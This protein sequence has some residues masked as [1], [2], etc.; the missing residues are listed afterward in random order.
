MKLTVNDRKCLW[1]IRHKS[2]EE[3][4]TIAEKAG[5]PEDKLEELKAILSE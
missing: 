5:V 1:I 3:I 2:T 4:L